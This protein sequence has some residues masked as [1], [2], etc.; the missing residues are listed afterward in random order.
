MIRKRVFRTGDGSH[1]YAK[2]AL[3]EANQ[4]KESEKDVRH[5]WGFG[6]L[7]FLVK[8]RQILIYHVHVGDDDMLEEEKK[9]IKT[10]HRKE[11]K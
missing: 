10:L 11:D 6:K 3:N 7:I 8:W 4:N 9:N 1:R 2:A 5:Y